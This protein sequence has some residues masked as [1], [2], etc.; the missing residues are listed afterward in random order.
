[1]RRRVH[2]TG[3]ADCNA[4][5][6]AQESVVS[7]ET[8]GLVQTVEPLKPGMAAECLRCGSYIGRP[9]TWRSLEVT[10]ALTLAALVLYVPANIYPI[11]KMHLYGGYSESTVWDRSEEHTSELQSQSNLV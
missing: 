4:I 6:M 3:H 9:T 2:E 5:L 1:M 10:A 7:C 11:M 8:C